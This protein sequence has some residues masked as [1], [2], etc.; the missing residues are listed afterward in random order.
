M[1]KS[2]G[3]KKLNAAKKDEVKDLFAKLA[4]ENSDDEGSKEKG[5]DLG[6][7]NKGDMVEEFELDRSYKYPKIYENG[8]AAGAYTYIGENTTGKETCT[9]AVIKAQ[10]VKKVDGVDKPLELAIWNN[11]EYVGNENLRAAVANTLKNTYFAMTVED[12]GTIKYTGLKP[13]DLKCVA[14]GTVDAPEYVEAAS[15]LFEKLVSVLGLLY[16]RKNESLDDEIE[17][18]IEKRQEAR[19]NRDF[20]TADAIRDEL[21]AQGIIL[22][23]TPQGV[24]WHR[25]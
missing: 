8:K 3:Q 5:G 12:D 1:D 17:A 18:L 24:K 20:A 22:E 25:A 14:G 15:E 9:K 21:K 7:F 10:L 11:V 19:K 13:E 4:K 16:E 6:Y 2:K 23:D